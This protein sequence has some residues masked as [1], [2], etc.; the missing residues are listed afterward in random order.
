MILVDTSVLIAYLGGK[1]VRTAA[2]LQKLLDEDAA[3][4]LTPVVIQ[5]VLQGARDEKQWKL[6][7]RYLEGQPI[8]DA[9]DSVAHAIAAAR[10]YV[11]CR[12][13]GLTIRSSVD[14][15]IAQLALEHDLT[16]LH[17]DRDFET[18]ARVRPLRQL[19]P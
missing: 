8:V 2:A 18:I 5:E 17:D 14:C 15:W 19:R 11:D 4:F 13:K 3:F 12:R 7:H 10:I 9:A 16:L 1:P 6:L